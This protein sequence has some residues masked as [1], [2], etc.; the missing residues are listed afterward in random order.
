MVGT[1]H[2][3]VAVIVTAALARDDARALVVE[4]ALG[5]SEQFRNFFERA[6]LGDEHPD[7]AFGWRHL[8]QQC[9]CIVLGR[10]ALRAPAAARRCWPC[11]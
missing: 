6:A 3:V 10:A 4:S 8:A 5:F 7:F 1:Y 11:T 9:L 2:E